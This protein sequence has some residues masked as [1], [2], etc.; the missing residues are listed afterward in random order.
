LNIIPNNVWCF[1]KSVLVG[2]P[3]NI[4]NDTHQ[5]RNG[6][7]FPISE[8]DLNDMFLNNITIDLEKLD[9]SNINGPHKEI[10]YVFKKS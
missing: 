4:V 10:E 6:L 5:N 9:F 2:I 3:V 7:E 8:K 1:K